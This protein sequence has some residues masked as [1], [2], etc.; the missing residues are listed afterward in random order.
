[1]DKKQVLQAILD[2]VSEGVMAL[3]KDWKIVVWNDAA[4]RITGFQK[5]E[6][7]GNEC[8]SVFWQGG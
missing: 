7:L 5:E 2:S 6:V 8:R 4:E 1:M 3:D